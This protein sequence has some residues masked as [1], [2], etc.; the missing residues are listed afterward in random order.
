M[1]QAIKQTVT[2]KAAGRIEI[3][4]SELPEGT[5]AEVI[6]LVNEAQ[7]PE[8][9]QSELQAA[10]AKAQGIVRQHVPEGQSLSEELIQER[11]A[12]SARE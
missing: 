7:R 8:T 1:I 4:A 9:Q 10:I 2:V 3:A 5:E 6:V 11:R 12:E